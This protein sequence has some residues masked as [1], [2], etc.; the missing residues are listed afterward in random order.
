MENKKI[1]DLKEIKSQAEDIVLKADVLIKQIRS[2]WN[3]ETNNMIDKLEAHLGCELHHLRPNDDGEINKDL[4]FE[5]KTIRKSNKYTIVIDNK[6]FKR[7][8]KLPKKIF[9]IMDEWMI[10]IIIDPNGSLLYGNNYKQYGTG[11]MENHRLKGCQQ[12]RTG[13]WRMLWRYNGEDLIN[14]IFLGSKAEAVKIY[15]I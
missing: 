8:K 14:I 2:D 3:K 4:S 12:M 9:H 1:S 5:L 7:M 10:K 6:S 15:K 11:K 13:D